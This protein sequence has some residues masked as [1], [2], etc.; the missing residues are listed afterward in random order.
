MLFAMGIPLY[1]TRKQIPWL[2]HHLRDRGYLPDDESSL[3]KVYGP[4]V[5]QTENCNI[6]EHIFKER[7]NGEVVI[8]DETLDT[9]GDCE[10]VNIVVVTNEVAYFCI[11]L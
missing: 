8:V 1:S 11:F 3:Q 10:L 2:K 6:L 5:I 4:S 9:M 7:D